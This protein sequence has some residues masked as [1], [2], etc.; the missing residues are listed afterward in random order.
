GVMPAKR[1][2][3]G[4]RYTVSD[5]RKLAAFVEALIEI[6]GEGKAEI[7]AE[8]L[9]LSGAQVSRMRHG[10]RPAL[11][12]ATVDALRRGVSLVRDDLRAAGTGVR[13]ASARFAELT[14]MLASAV[15]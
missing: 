12:E 10:R 9:A 15:R 11:D 1:V 6:V 4:P 7:L 3:R 2:R 5:P 8:R 14:G 13:A